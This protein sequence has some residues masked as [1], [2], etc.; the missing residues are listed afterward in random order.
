MVG[1]CASGR[2]G[3]DRNWQKVG[4]NDIGEGE[5]SPFLKR[6]NGKFRRS[7]KEYRDRRSTGLVQNFR[8]YLEGFLL[9]PAPIL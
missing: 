8:P 1:C 7:P 6:D 9:D 2:V 3:I 5:V 4:S